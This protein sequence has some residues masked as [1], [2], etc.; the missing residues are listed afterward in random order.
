VIHQVSGNH[1]LDDSKA[2]RERVVAAGAEVAQS[3]VLSTQE[4]LKAHAHFHALLSVG[5]VPWQGL[6]I[7]NTLTLHFVDLHNLPVTPTSAAVLEVCV[8]VRRLTAS[9]WGRSE[10]GR[11][12]WRWV[13]PSVTPLRAPLSPASQ[14]PGRC[15]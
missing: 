8:I 1:R 12:D 7:G 11:A 4:P 14:K 5:T 13:A 3:E 9:L 6:S 2:E 10:S 15:S